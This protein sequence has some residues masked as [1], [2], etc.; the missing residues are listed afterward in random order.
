MKLER[1]KFKYQGYYNSI[2]GC[3]VP[4][5][6]VLEYVEPLEAERLETAVERATTNMVA[7]QN[8]VAELEKR[9]EE[10]ERL[11]DPFENAPGGSTPEGKIALLQ[12]HLW[13]SECLR[14]ADAEILGKEIAIKDARIERLKRACSILYF[15]VEDYLRRLAENE[16]SGCA[17][18]QRKTQ[19]ELKELLEA[20]G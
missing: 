15:G 17:S 10:L 4:C 18:T 8:R 1:R 14:K 13:S 3:P 16:Y 19:T 11:E 6:C 20:K 7:A 12:N 9:V 5:E 2:R